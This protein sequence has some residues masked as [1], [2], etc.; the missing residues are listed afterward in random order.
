MRKDVKAELST[1]YAIKELGEATREELLHE[2]KKTYKVKLSD[3]KLIRILRRWKAK[4]VLSLNFVDGEEVYKMADVPMFPKLKIAHLKKMADKEAGKIIEELENMGN[5]AGHVVE[6]RN[7]W[8]DYVDLNLTFENIDPILGGDSGKTNNRRLFP[9]GAD[10]KLIIRRGWMLGWLRE[11]LRLMDCP[12]TV[13]SYIAVSQGD[14]IKQPKIVNLEAMT[15]KGPCTY[16]AIPAGTKFKMLIRFPM[17]GSK[18]RT[19]EE[20]IQFLKKAEVAPIRGFG[21]NPN[22]YGG[23]IRAL[24]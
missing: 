3:K 21:A 11:N 13:K 18:V 4:E 2:L 16:E 19:A 1:L 6:T 14:F 7:K 17:Q 12:G 8:R 10:G 22:V 20:F 15:P 5:E 24:N 23:R 9:R